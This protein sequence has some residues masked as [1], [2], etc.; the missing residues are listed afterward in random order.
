[1]TDQ[2]ELVGW[3]AL[4]PRLPTLSERIAVRMA[5]RG[6]FPAPVRFSPRT[7]PLWKAVEVESW[8]S[9][10]LGASEVTA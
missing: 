8:I 10:R 9:Q 6:E 1:M 4:A 3:E 5:A 7:P 2:I